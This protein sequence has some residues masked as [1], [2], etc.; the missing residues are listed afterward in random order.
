[1]IKQAFILAAGLGTR[2][3]HLTENIPKALVKVNGIPMLQL[4]I[5]RLQ[6]VGIGSF[7]INIHHHGQQILDFLEENNN[8]GATIYISD[9]RDSLLDTGGALRKM[10]AYLSISNPILIHNVD[11]IS[12]IDLTALKEFHN[13]T[14]ALATLCVRKRDSGRQLLFDKEMN[15]TGWQNVKSGEFKWVNQPTENFKPFAFSGVYLA[16]PEFACN[17]PFSGKFSIIDAWLEMAPE[18]KIVGF[19]D[20]S[21]AWFDLGTEEKIKEAEMFLKGGGLD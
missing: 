4:L 11:V 18:H 9:E 13:K 8:F 20:T 5:E 16:D 12:E 1:M 21:P 17:M 2:L 10:K 3:G 7:I 6:K 14:K 19:N 15:L